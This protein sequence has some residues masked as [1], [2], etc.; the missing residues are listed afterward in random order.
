MFTLVNVIGA[1]ENPDQ[2]LLKLADSD[3]TV[4][5]SRDKPYQ[6]VNAYSADLRYDMDT[7]K[8][9]RT[10]LRVGAVI[11]FGGDSYTVVDIKPDEVVLLA[12]SNQKKTSLRYAP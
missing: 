2:L 11:A 10:G 12:Q 9:V 3:E 5:V 4:P 6:R 8:F 1:P 7:P